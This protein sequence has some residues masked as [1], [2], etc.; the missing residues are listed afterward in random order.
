[1]VKT[2][3]IMRQKMRTWSGNRHSVMF[4]AQY[5]DGRVAYFVVDNHG[6]ASGD[7]LAAM[8]ANERQGNGEIPAGEIASVKRV[9]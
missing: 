4:A 5:R 2:M 3:N 7:H 9:R 6:P 8:I 1:M